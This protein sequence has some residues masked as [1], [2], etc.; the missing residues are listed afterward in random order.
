[1]LFKNLTN[2][3]EL[4]KLNVFDYLPLTFVVNVDLQTYSPDFEK[5]SRCYD[6]F[7]TAIN[8]IDKNIPDYDNQCIKLINNKLQQIGLFKERRSI[9]HCQPK[10]VD[11]HFAGKNIWILKP[12]G[13]NR[14]QGISVFNSM[15]KQIGRAHV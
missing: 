15:K 3:A 6:I 14:G 11:T 10:I 1:M 13:F 5:F 7:Q 4:N 2:Y 8:E 9:S 12:T